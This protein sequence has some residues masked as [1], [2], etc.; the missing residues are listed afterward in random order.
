MTDLETDPV[1]FLSWLHKNI[2]L[3]KA[4]QLERLDYDGESLTLTVPLGPNVNDKGTGFGGSIAALATL[5]GWCL[6]TLQLREQGLDCDVVIAR[7]EQLFEA[8]VTG[9][10][11]ARVARPDSA[12]CQAFI[13]RVATR[14]RGRL[15]LSVDVECAGERAFTMTGQYAAIRRQPGASQ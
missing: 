13:E 4:M 12:S 6:T 14:G 15:E 11:T 1:Q 5:A 10:F 8:P 9:A 7:S 3:T 2:P